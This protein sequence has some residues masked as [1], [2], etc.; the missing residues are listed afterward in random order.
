MIVYVLIQVEPG[1]VSQ[2]RNAVAACLWIKETHEVMGPYDVIAKATVKDISEI[3]SKLHEIQSLDGVE[4][5]L[6][7]TTLD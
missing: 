3:R 1:Y 7:L 5:T 2:V 6:S 4:H